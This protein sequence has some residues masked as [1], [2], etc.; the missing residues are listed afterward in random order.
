MSDEAEVYWLQMIPPR[1]SMTAVSLAINHPDLWVKLRGGL[2]WFGGAP[3]V[4]AAGCAVGCAV[5]VG[6]LLD[7][8]GI[9]YF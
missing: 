1:L 2:P 9:R 8:Y 3:V 7:D 6:S 4:G 5:G